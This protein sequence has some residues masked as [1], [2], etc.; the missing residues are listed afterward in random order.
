MDMTETTNTTTT[1]DNNTS[2][3]P[4]TSLE[5]EAKE[6][7][8]DETG[9]RAKTASLFQEERPG[10]GDEAA[11]EVGAE[12]TDGKDAGEAVAANDIKVPEGFTYDES[13]GRDFL[14]LINDSKLSRREMVQKLVDMHAAQVGR[15]AQAL[16]A[17][18][19]E[20]RRQFE[21]DMAK[22]KSEWLK[23]C[24]SDEE[25]GGQKWE[26]S[27]AVIDRGCSHVATPEA[28]KLLQRYNLHTHPEI[29]RMFYR[30]G[31]LAGED[32]SG[33]QGGGAGMKQNPA[34]AIFGESLKNWKSRGDNA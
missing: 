5:A 10:T 33:K 1:T 29:A 26:A 12:E 9:E 3:S 7:A 31:L 11:A 22:E 21:A 2:E 24:K 30:A 20:S 27:Q 28:V 34:E 13:V 15:M 19:A 14:S 32:R 16:E 25:F 4:N 6:A 18:E 23:A 8:K 17:S